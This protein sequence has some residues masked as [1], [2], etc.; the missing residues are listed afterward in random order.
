MAQTTAQDGVDDRRRGLARTAP[1]FPKAGFP[2]YDAAAA[3][4]SGS[5]QQ[6]S[7]ASAVGMGPDRRERAAVAD[8]VDPF[9][10]VDL[11]GLQTAPTAATGDEPGPG[12]PDQRRG[13]LRRRGA[14]QTGRDFGRRRRACPQAPPPQASPSR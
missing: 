6:R 3:R 7:A 1:A 9:R 5:A 4:I 12:Q 14:E 8:P 13:A 10:R 11:D 2:R